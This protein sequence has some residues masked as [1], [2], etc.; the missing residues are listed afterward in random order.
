MSKKFIVD[1]I[2]EDCIRVYPEK[3]EVVGKQ[4]EVQKRKVTMYDYGSNY[5]FSL[6]PPVLGKQKPGTVFKVKEFPCVAIMESRDRY[7]I[8]IRFSK[9]ALSDACGIVKRDFKEWFEFLQER[10]K[11]EATLASATVKTPPTPLKG[12]KTIKSKTSKNTKK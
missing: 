11:A 2:A 9:S 7:H 1:R 8:N 12:E 5:G 6:T 4:P 10:L 3:Q